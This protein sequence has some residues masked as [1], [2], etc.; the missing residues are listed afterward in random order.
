[1]L[2]QTTT[3]L[4]QAFS[5][6]PPTFI[7]YLT[8]PSERLISLK[9]KHNHCI[10]G[11]RS[12]L[13]LELRS[14]NRLLMPRLSSLLLLFQ[15]KQSFGPLFATFRNSGCAFLEVIL[16]QM[17]V[18]GPQSTEPREAPNLRNSQLILGPLCPCQIAYYNYSATLELYNNDK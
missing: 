3:E 1:M 13:V 6:R 14:E 9:L 4:P 2:H 8:W 18:L 16:F 5:F 10:L 7:P 11:Q 15:E 12:P 17:Q